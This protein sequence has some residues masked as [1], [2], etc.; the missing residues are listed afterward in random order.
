MKAWLTRA[1][2]NTVL[3]GEQP[4]NRLARW[5]RWFPT[6]PTVEASR[7]QGVDEPYPRHWRKFPDASPPVDAA[8]PAVR[9]KLTEAIDELPRPWRDVLIA[10][11]VLDR[12]ATEIGD[13]R[14]LTPGQQRAMLNRARARVRERLAQRFA[15]GGDA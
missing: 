13:Q 5:S 12:S 4:R 14:G 2:A 11:D 1:T 6:T 10:R 15:G 3:R 9:D 8:D 7:F